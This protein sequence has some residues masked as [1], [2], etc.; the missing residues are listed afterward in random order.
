MANKKFVPKVKKNAYKKLT[1]DEMVKFIEAEVPADKSWFKEIAFQDKNGNKVDKYNHLNA[2]LQF[3]KRY[4]PELIPERKEKKNK[5]D[6][7][8]DW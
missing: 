4:A 1:F 5:T 3:C 8:A 2:K 6:I 7:L